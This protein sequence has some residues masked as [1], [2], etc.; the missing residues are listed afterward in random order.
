MSNE[1]NEE[2]VINKTYQKINYSIRPAKCVERKM[3]CEAF[4]R[5]SHFHRI[6]TYR[7][8]G[9]GSTFFSDFS[10]FHR[11]LGFTSMVSIEHNEDDQLRFEFNKPYKCI[12]L[13][14]GSSHEKL[15]KLEW[16]KPTILWVD[17][18]GNLNKDVL[19][20]IGVFCTKATHGSV[21]VI[22]VNA[23]TISLPKD[24]EEDFTVFE[25]RMS[26]LIKQVGEKRIPQKTKNTDLIPTKQSTVLRNIIN[27]EIQELIAAR[28]GGLPENEKLEYEQLFNISYQ[29]GAKMLTV[30]GIL[31]KSTESEYFKRCEFEKLEF[32][33][34]GEEAF[35][36][37][38]PN[39]TFR[40]IRFLDKK[41]PQ[42]N[43]EEDTLSL[44][45]LGDCIPKEDI[46]N[47]KKI[48]RYFPNF[49]ETEM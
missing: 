43:G 4:Q 9:F 48:Y 41:L 2:K 28:N 40:E 25:Y 47:Y 7:Y 21:I 6:E 27:N 42:E 24:K 8:I 44:I 10:L 31:F 1:P 19:S 23:H 3:L 14:F 34:A 15:P 45:E 16:D 11:V 37:G 38:I 5:L 36:I 18:D 33:R 39:L 26:E 20:D 32:Y 35:S 46:D 49:T 13:L 22:T 29:D 12:Q 17:Y 30:G